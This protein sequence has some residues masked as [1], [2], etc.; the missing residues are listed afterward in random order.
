MI[1]I[2]INTNNNN[3]NKMNINNKRDY[4]A[5]FSLKSEV[6]TIKY[7]AAHKPT[8]MITDV[9]LRSQK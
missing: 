3:N 2:N 1:I 8:K 6:I 5:I 7:I 4:T 9:T